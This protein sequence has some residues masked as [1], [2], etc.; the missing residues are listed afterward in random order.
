MGEPDPDLPRKS[1]SGLLT[2]RR[3][4]FVFA[5]ERRDETMTNEE[6]H[7]QMV[8]A[9]KAKDKTRLSI[10]RQVMAEVKNVEVNERRDATEEDVN[11]MIKRLIKQTGETLEM[12]IK[13][14]TNAERTETLAEQVKILESLLPAQLS[15][16]ELVALIE[17]TIAGLGATS[18]KDMGRV[19]DA[20][21]KATGGNFDKPWRP[22]R[23]VPA[24]RRMPLSRRIP[25][26]C[27]DTHESAGHPDGAPRPFWADVTGSALVSAGCRAAG[28]SARPRT[29]SQGPCRTSPPRSEWFFSTGPCTLRLGKV[30]NCGYLGP[31]RLQESPRGRVRENQL[32]SRGRRRR[33]KVRPS[34]CSEF[35][36]PVRRAAS[37]RRTF[38]VPHGCVELAPQELPSKHSTTLMC[39]INSAMGIKRRRS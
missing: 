16:D 10:I 28:L 21:T 15:G 13:A 17:S 33:G 14:G 11:G 1:G 22:A 31:R 24:W 32:T 4:A 27:I 35:V 2:M 6:L 20:L 37:M 8:A 38:C 34:E 23:W 36:A 25:A 26:R 7:E 18:K 3:R 19:M 5:S 12:S 39:I 30:P 29:A 9:M